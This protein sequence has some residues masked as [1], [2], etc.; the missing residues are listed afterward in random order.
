ME[1][2]DLG[3]KPNPSAKVIATP[4]VTIQP[5]LVAFERFDP[6][7]PSDFRGPAHNGRASAVPAS[8]ALTLRNTAELKL[9]QVDVIVGD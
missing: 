9:G 7:S 4:L 8:N 5:D 3:R 6:A 1:H 2:D